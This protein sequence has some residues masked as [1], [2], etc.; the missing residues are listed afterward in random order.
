MLAR[1]LLLRAGPE[2]LSG[3]SSCFRC[4]V[5]FFCFSGCCA[6]VF[7]SLFGFS[8]PKVLVKFPFLSGPFFAHFP[9]YWVLFC[10]PFP[11]PLLLFFLLLLRVAGPGFLSCLLVPCC[12][13]YYVVR[14][15]T[16]AQHLS[17]LSFASSARAG[18]PRFFSLSSVF[19][20]CLCHSPAPSLA[21][22]R[23][24][25]CER[26][27][28]SRACGCARAL[29]HVWHAVAW[30]WSHKCVRA[31]AVVRVRVRM[32]VRVRGGV[33]ECVFV[34][35]FMFVCACACVCVCVCVYVFV[36][37]RL[38]AGMC[39]PFVSKG[40]TTSSADLGGSSN[41]QMRVF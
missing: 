3:A 22:L 28:P 2:I 36:R 18:A 16:A 26:V 35:V 15:R 24:R 10:L 29:V 14:W 21:C 12:Q 8:L 39:N 30:V 27:V 5:A 6:S 31:G 25:V 13:A 1:S 34:I 32:R 7:G 23:T 37:L 20:L 40:V 11:L 41:F 33:C 4:L 9:R 19:S 38:C 17:V